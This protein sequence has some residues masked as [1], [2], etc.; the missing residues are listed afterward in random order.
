MATRN[1]VRPSNV[2]GKHSRPR[3]LT[4]TQANFGESPHALHLSPGRAGGDV[5]RPQRAADGNDAPRNPRLARLL[6]LRTIT[7][8]E[9]SE[10]R[11]EG[12]P[13]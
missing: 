7:M 10:G 4:P 1:R 3:S 13:R 5:S 11:P 12:G 6:T 9:S 8:T 2:K